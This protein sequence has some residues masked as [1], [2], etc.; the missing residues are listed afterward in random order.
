M[1]GRRGGGGNRGGTG[2]GEGRMGGTK[3]GS[4]PSGYCICPSCG[5]KVPHQVGQPCYRMNCPQCGTRMARE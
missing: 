1:S 2:G 4:G 5:H 3:P